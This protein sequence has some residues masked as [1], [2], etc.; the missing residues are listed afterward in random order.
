MGTLIGFFLA[1]YPEVNLEASDLPECL[2]T[3]I[4]NKGLLPCMNPDVLDSVRIRLKSLFTIPTRV[5]FFIVMYF[6]VSFE[7]VEVAE[8]LVAVVTFMCLYTHMTPYMIIEVSN[9]DE[10]LGAVGTVIWPLS[11]VRSHVG[12]ERSGDGESV[13][14]RRAL[15]RPLT[16]VGPEVHL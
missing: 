4:A 11:G 3:N 6:H 10:L 13:A 8:R 12:L 16:C 15:V 7:T 1:M 14:A 5:G 2:L 9:V